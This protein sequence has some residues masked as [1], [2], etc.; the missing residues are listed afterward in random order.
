[1][2]KIGTLNDSVNRIPDFLNVCA[3]LKSIPIV[4]K[5]MDTWCV[6][7]AHD[8]TLATEFWEHE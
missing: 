5:P 2:R 1:M 7:Q 6:G 3:G 8:N 4:M